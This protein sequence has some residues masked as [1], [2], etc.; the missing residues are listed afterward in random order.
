MGLGFRAWALGS[1]QL[2]A[3]PSLKSS[4]RGRNWWFLETNATLLFAQGCYVHRCSAFQEVFEYQSSSAIPMLLQPTLLL[5][6]KAAAPGRCLSVLVGGDNIRRAAPVAQ[7][8]RPLEVDLRASGTAT[9]T[10]T[11]LRHSQVPVQRPSGG[12][13]RT[14]PSPPLR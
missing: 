10:A 13:L 5:A 7:T 3:V 11:T 4:A 8:S 6:Q 12:V 1:R 14:L 9:R 2:S